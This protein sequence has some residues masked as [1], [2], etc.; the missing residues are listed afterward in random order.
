MT[1]YQ[2][3]R[4]NCYVRYDECSNAL[5]EIYED[6]DGM[7]K[8]EITALSGPNEFAEFYSRFKQIKDFHRRHPGEV[9]VKVPR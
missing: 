6:K 7:R 4:D 2:I 9:M 3:I 8:E 5:R 1:F